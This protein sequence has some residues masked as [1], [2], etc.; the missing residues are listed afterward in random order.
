MTVEPGTLGA[1]LRNNTATPAQAVEIEKAGY[2]TVWL[3]GS[4][5]ADLAVAERLLDATERVTVATGIVNVWTAD[6]RS[7]AA[8]YHRIAARHPGRFL[9]GIGAGHPEADAAYASPYETVVAYLD[10]LAAHGVPADRVVL[11]ALGPKMLRLARDRTAGTVPVL[12][13]PEHARRA[14]EILGAGPLVMPGQQVLLDDDAARARAA[15]RAAVGTPALHVV[16]YTSNLRRLGFT[17]ADLTDPGSDRLIDALVLHGDAAAVAAGLVAHLDAG[18]DHVGV[19]VAGGD[20]L[21]TLRS[22]A[23]AVARLRSEG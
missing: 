15:G 12:V 2:G 16:N 17:E 10:A 4:P 20:T 5:P 3:V 11:A 18:A 21:R 1:H 7:V 8:S 19:T 6:V 22:V 13:T 14:R 9:L 23:E